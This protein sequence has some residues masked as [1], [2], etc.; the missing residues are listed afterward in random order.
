MNGETNGRRTMTDI[1]L[2]AVYRATTWKQCGWNSDFPPTRLRPFTWHLFSQLY[3]VTQRPT[4][5]FLLG[6]CNPRFWENVSWHFFCCS[7]LQLGF[8]TQ[9][10]TW[11]GQSVTCYWANMQCYCLV[12]SSSSRNANHRFI[13]IHSFSLFVSVAK[14]HSLNINSLKTWTHKK[15]PTVVDRMMLSVRSSQCRL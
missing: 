12:R 9:I 3:T 8:A 7:T 6:S 13:L 5:A 10:Y 2:S 11:G 4:S 15:M 1:T 14:T